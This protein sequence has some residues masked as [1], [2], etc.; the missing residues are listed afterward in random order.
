MLFPTRLWILHFNP[1]PS[2]EGWRKPIRHWQGLDCISIHNLHP[3]VDSKLSQFSHI[4]L[5][6]Y[7]QIIYCINSR[8]YFFISLNILSR[9]ISWNIWCESPS[10][11]MCTGHS[12][13]FF[14]WNSPIKS[15]IF[16]I[17]WILFQFFVYSFLW[18]VFSIIP[19]LLYFVL[20]Q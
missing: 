16:V 3:K 4:C 12:H 5:L 8:F 13:L 6:H 20:F 10:I 15:A 11:F 2:S 18:F 9:N 19:I 17:S 7:Y 14:R 1:Q